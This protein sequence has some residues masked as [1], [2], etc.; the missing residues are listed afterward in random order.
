MY[1]CD[2]LTI[3]VSESYLQEKKKQLIDAPETTVL[4]EN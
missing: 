4:I 2:A 3:F 1:K